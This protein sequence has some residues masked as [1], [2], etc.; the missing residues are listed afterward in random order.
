MKQ[1]RNWLSVIT[2]IY[3]VLILAVHPIIFQDKYHNILNVKYYFYCACTIGVIVL[4]AGYLLLPA[5]FKQFMT[6][7]KEKKL[8]Q[9]FTPTDL[10][11]IAFALLALLSALFS[12]WQ[13]EAFWGNEG[14]LS[15]AFLLT[16]YALAYFCVVKNLNFR[17][18]Y[19]DLALFSGLLVCLFGLTDFFQMDLLHFKAT[20]SDAQK[21]IFTSFIG[22]INMYT[23]LVSVYMGASSIMWIACKS[24]WKSALYL[25]NVWITYFA[26]I[27]GESENAY[28]AL[29]ASFAFIPLYA[30]H[31]RQGI[32]RYV[33]LLASFLSSLKVVQLVSNIFADRVFTI[34][35][36]Y[37]SLVHSR[38]VVYAMIG[39]WILAAILYV[40]DFKI[41]Q[42]TANTNMAT[43]TRSVAS[44]SGIQSDAN[45]WI[46][47]I[48]KILICIGI[49]GVLFL[50]FDANVLGHGDRYGSA[51]SFLVFNDNWGTNRG[52]IWRIALENYK[53]F[54]PLHKLFGHG[55]DT[56]G[57]ITLFHNADEMANVYKML[58]DSAHND[59]LQIFVTNGPLGLIAYLAIYITAFVEIVKKASDKPAVIA[60]MYGV[61]CYSAQAVVNIGTPI[62]I[63]IVLTF[64]YV[65]LAG[66]QENVNK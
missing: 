27:T 59:Y 38:L 33:V 16:L 57:L 64:L 41:H 12:D 39:L 35:S 1:K 37:V 14:R 54:S 4:T 43:G 66:C 5:N 51:A 17:S 36:L 9:I 15:G 62:T 50:L 60:L 7:F 13:Y 31:T 63:P 24:K 30:F 18:W 61:I 26:L 49:V 29:A 22:N 44:P 40:F 46:L 20:I 32:R 10:A 23:A 2:M 42:S 6:Y 21:R 11:V 48:W 52:Y 25:A 55:P 45:P 34:E 65:A 19:L 53:N 3:V 58:F 47:K 8:S 28:L 56:F